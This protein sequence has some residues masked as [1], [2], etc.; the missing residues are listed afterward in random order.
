MDDLRYPVGK[1]EHEGGITTEHIAQ[2]VDQIEALPVQV[3]AA[4]SGLSEEQLSMPYRPGGWTVRQVV[5]HIGDSHMNS[6]VRFKWTLTEDEPTI[7]A[8]NQDRWAELADYR[9]VPP[10]TSLL[11]LETLHVRLVA[12]LRS[13]SEDDL[14]RR[15]IH[16]D[17][18]PTTL[19]RTVG[20]YAWH[21]R[22]HVAHITELRKR[23]GWA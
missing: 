17:S 23:K 16:P 9:D 2:W 20:M 21:G 18:G 8:Y 13:L 15:F 14:A 10:E 4:V 6:L 19:A 7:K 22:H 3:R 11:F 12:L 1:F 5:H